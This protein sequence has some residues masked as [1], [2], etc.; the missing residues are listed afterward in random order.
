MDFIERIFGFSPDNGSGTFE[1]S[2]VIA[3]IVVI[4]AIYFYRRQ[5]SSRK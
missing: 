3:V 4:A 5:K 1:G 2:I